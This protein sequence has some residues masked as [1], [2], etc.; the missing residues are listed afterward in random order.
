LAPRCVWPHSF[1]GLLVGLDGYHHVI[2]FLDQ[3][4]C[5]RLFHLVD[6]CVGDFDCCI[7]LLFHPDLRLAL[8]RLVAFFVI[9]LA[10]HNFSL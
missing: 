9:E 7:F 5:S 2:L 6:I 1:V 3:I 8:V 10:N 4:W